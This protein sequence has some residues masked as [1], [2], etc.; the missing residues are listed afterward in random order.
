MFSEEMVK[1][2]AT[3]NM[4]AY[5][6]VRDLASSDSHQLRTEASDIQRRTF[7]D[8][9]AETLL[10]LEVSRL[11]L[12]ALRED[13]WVPRP[14]PYSHSKLADVEIDSNGLVDISNFDRGKGGYCVGD[15][16]YEIAP[17]T[18]ARN[19]CFWTDSAIRALPPE[20]KPR[21]RL[22]PYMRSSRQNY[23][24]AFNKMHVFGAHLDWSKI[25]G[26]RDD[27]THRWMPNNPERSNWAFTDVVWNPR[28]KEIHLRCEEC[29]KPTACD[30]RAARYF[31]SIFSLDKGSVIHCDGALRIF[32]KEQSAA[33][34]TKHV[35]DAGKLGTRVK[36]F[37]IDGDIG[38][39]DWLQLF[40]SFFVWNDDIETLA[41]SL[42]TK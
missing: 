11:R 30:Y 29:P 18:E 4:P 7:A 20:T 25:V 16:V 13:R 39:S 23:R 32:T 42:A 2:V 10:E 3:S 27:S 19:S 22:D 38:E 17:I 33:R 34:L 31:H 28:G 26:L 21:V 24:S 40:G 6:T 41:T 37:Q 8:M 15:W 35:R 36:I 12:S 1:Y 9:A 5:V 14:A